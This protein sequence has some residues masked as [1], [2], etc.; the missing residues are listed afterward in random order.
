MSNYN[1][2]HLNYGTP[3]QLAKIPLN[4]K[5]KRT[6]W[7]GISAD[8]FEDGEET[9][10]KRIIKLL[11]EHAKQKFA[12]NFDSNIDTCH[13]D[14]CDLCANSNGLGVAIALIKEENNA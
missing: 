13:E 12:D 3:E 4:D 11:E 2:L 6:G 5:E 9:E 7:K 10:R 1:P 14:V 8:A